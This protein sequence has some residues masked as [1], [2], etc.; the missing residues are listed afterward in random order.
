MRSFGKLS[1]VLISFVFIS[2]VVSGCSTVQ[3]IPIKLDPHFKEKGINTIVL[4]PVID[5]RVDKKAQFDFEKDLRIPAKKILEKKGYEVIAPDYFS[6]NNDITSEQVADMNISE[7]CELGPKNAKA[8][9][10][11]YVEDILD[12]YVV[13]AYTFK[14]EATGSLIEKTEKLELWRDKGI[15][16]YGQGGLISGVLS[17][18]YKQTAVSQ[19]LDGMLV[20]LPNNES[21]S[22]RKDSTQT[23]IGSKKIVPDD[24][25]VVPQ[26]AVATR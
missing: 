8:L 26:A 5:R 1:G 18:M 17:G 19:C 9:L 13:L 20:T 10:C 23:Q 7:L 11:I 3:K 15:G 24:R 6:D 12:D 21:Q 16:A 14:I 25:N 2:F 22:P 4:M